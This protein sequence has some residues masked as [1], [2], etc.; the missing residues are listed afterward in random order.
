MHALDSCDS[1][2][3]WILQAQ[4]PPLNEYDSLLMAKYKYSKNH[5]CH[6]F[7]VHHVT[8]QGPA[9]H[10]LYLPLT[11]QWPK[12]KALHGFVCGRYA[13]LINCSCWHE[14]SCPL[15]HGST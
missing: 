7:D 10:Q 6:A 1:E 4:F 8:S 2:D 13:I 12:E 15:L 11:S 9:I 14:I 5:A 3:I